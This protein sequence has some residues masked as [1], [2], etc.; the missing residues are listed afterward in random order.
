MELPSTVFKRRHYFRAMNIISITPTRLRTHNYN[1]KRQSADELRDVY[2][3]V[4][5][6][7]ERF[8]PRRVFIDLKQ[9]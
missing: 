2:T 5:N 3:F 1:V 8:L 4:R 6:E 9:Y 7:T